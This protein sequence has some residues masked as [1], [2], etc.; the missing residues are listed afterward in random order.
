[1]KSPGSTTDEKNGNDTIRTIFVKLFQQY[2]S[3]QRLQLSEITNRFWWMYDFCKKIG[4][5]RYLCAEI[6]L[7]FHGFQHQGDKS[8]ESFRA[9][10]GL[11]NDDTHGIQA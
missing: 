8:A 4:I 10:V 6:S 11:R 1:M 2:N 7:H 3:V 5:A 9:M